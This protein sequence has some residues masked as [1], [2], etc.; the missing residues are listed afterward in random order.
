MSD[1]VKKPETAPAA[2]VSE[3]PE[4][5]AWKKPEFTAWNVDITQTSPSVASDSTEAGFS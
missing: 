5:K 3:N 4:T 2:D 1:E